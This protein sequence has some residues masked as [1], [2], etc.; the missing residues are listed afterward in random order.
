MYILAAKSETGANDSLRAFARLFTVSQFFE[1]K[2]ME[3]NKQRGMITRAGWG[4]GWWGGG[5][6]GGG[7]E[8]QLILKSIHVFMEKRNTGKR[9]AVNSLCNCNSI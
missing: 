8:E 5:E 3:D 6:G 9:T 4:W 1:H 2:L 7:G